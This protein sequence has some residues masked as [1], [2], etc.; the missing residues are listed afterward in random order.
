LCAR[1][2]ALGKSVE[3]FTYPG[4]PHTFFGDGDQLF[5]Q[6]TIAFFDTHL[7]GS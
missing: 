6:R 4:Q 7:K 3:C 2:T 1:L 5:I